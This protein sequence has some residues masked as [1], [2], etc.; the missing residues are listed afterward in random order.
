MIKVLSVF[1]TRPEAIKMVSVIRS[2]TESGRYQTDVCVTGQHRTMLDQVL[3]LFSIV[4]AS[5]LNVMRP[6]QELPDLA[7]RAILVLGE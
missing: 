4:P 3:A 5:D 1:G 2:L 6:G 7:S